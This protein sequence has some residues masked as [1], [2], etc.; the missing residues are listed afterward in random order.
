MS[1]SQTLRNKTF[2]ATSRKQRGRR[3]T[4]KRRRRPSTQTTIYLNPLDENENEED[5]EDAEEP[6]KTSILNFLYGTT[7]VSPGELRSALL[8]VSSSAPAAVLPPTPPTPS[9]N[10]A[11][12]ILHGNGEYSVT[13]TTHSIGLE[14][15]VADDDHVKLGYD[16]RA[17]RPDTAASSAGVAAHDRLLALSSIQARDMTTDDVGQFIRNSARPITLRFLEK[18]TNPAQ[19]VPIFIP[20][21]QTSKAIFNPR[22]LDAAG[23]LQCRHPITPTREYLATLKEAH[24]SKCS[25]RMMEFTQEI[26]AVDGKGGG[27][28]INAAAALDVPEAVAAAMTAA[29]MFANGRRRSGRISRPTFSSSSSASSASNASSAPPT[30]SAARLL[31]ASVRGSSLSR[32]A[33]LTPAM[34][35]APAAYKAAYA[36]NNNTT[37]KKP[38]K[39]IRAKK[40][41]VPCPY[42]GEVKRT[43]SNG[44]SKGK[45]LRECMN[46]D[47]SARFY[48][49]DPV[50][51]K[52]S[53]LNNG[54]RGPVKHVI[55]KDKIKKK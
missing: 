43:R 37:K 8:D 17:V 29:A 33:T 5:E 41:K 13:F 30:S 6:V 9:S 38:K 11:Q 12:K 3:P 35:L 21:I 31:L 23:L 22:H 48:R 54:H 20:G 40:P 52:A 36:K 42:C 10:T 19:H 45:Y 27:S 47:C 44:S 51:L 55:M 26:V 4:K 14:F 16:I 34:A 1:L 28:G 39:A 24:P 53:V 7:S 15:G 25:R 18:D 2:K 50:T 32:N 49:V 46:T